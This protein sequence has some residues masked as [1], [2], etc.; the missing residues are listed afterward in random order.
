[1]E[2]KST[3][4]LAKRFVDPNFKHNCES[5]NFSIWCI[6]STENKYYNSFV[7]P[8]HE[9]WFYTIGVDWHKLVCTAISDDGLMYYDHK[10][11]FF[12]IVHEDDYYH[13]QQQ[14]PHEPDD[15]DLSLSYPLR[16]LDDGN[17]WYVWSVDMIPIG[18]ICICRDIVRTVKPPIL[19]KLRLNPTIF[20]EQQRTRIE[21]RFVGDSNVSWKYKPMS[22]WHKRRTVTDIVRR[23]TEYPTDLS[24]IVIYRKFFRESIPKYV[25]SMMYDSFGRSAIQMSFEL[26]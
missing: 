12:P 1:M 23:Y 19:L 9:I 3:Y 16:K 4:N 5:D 15:F 24:K 7:F 26:V 17:R 22:F 11:L 2:S 18:N 25:P 14:R 6:L 20:D 13:H 10:V 21:V 8:A